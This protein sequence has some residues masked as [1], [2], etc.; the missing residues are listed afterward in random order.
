VQKHELTRI[1]RY[2]STPQAIVLRC[3]IVLEAAKGTSN[4]Q[5]AREL[6]TTLPTALL[7]RRRYEQEGLDGI[8]QDKPRPGR[9]PRISAKQ[10]AEIIELTRNT[11]PKNGTHWTVRTMARRQGV[12]PA[13][14]QRIW[15]SYHL[16]PHRME[17]FKFST[18]PEFVHKVRDI[19]GLYLNPPDKALVLS[20]D[21]KSQIQALDRTQ[22]ILPGVCSL[23]QPRG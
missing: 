2:S 21:E 9:P 10:E 8:L 4:R 17:P 20:V 19:V 14:V 12:S 16:Q 23:P 7:W 5:L 18:D 6:E 13:T 22:P 15:K 1:V 3:R 11:K